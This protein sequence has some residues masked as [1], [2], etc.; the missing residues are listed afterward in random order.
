M[1]NELS[2]IFARMGSLMATED[3]QYY[4]NLLSKDMLI[5]KW[6]SN[7]YFYSFYDFN[8]VKYTVDFYHTQQEG[9]YKGLCQYVLNTIED[10]ILE[11][12]IKNGF[13]I[14]EEKKPIRY[15]IFNI[16]NPKSPSKPL[17]HNGVRCAHIPE[18]RVK[19]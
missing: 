2:N 10:P 8:F 16:E 12:F 4:F 3:E 18:A 14:L 6:I 1:K 9:D 7:D 19:I 15:S 17:F 11:S 13:E 5:N